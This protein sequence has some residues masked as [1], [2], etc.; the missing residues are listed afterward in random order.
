MV[1]ASS[2]GRRPAIRPRHARA[3]LV[4]EPAL[5]AARAGASALHDPTEGGLSAGL[6][7]MAEASGVALVVESERI[8]WFEPGVE[9]CVVAAGLDP[10]GTLASGDAAR[11][12]CIR[13]GGRCIAR[14][15]A[16][17]PL[18]VR[19]RS[20]R[21]R[22]RCHL[23]RRRSAHPLRTR[24][25]EPA[26]GRARRNDDRNDSPLA[27]PSFSAK[28][29][30]HS[31]EGMWRTTRANRCRETMNRHPPGG[32]GRDISGS[33]SHAF[34]RSAFCSSRISPSSI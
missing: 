2:D 20:R 12:V 30:R 23:H 21:A 14:S 3:S 29:G 31:V 28:A 22:V 18:G 13:P 9:L 1:S 16:R 7:E 15:R 4:V 17:R 10:W 5:A 8:L 11:G 25:A 24:R 26:L 32:I 19:H 6:H 34:P 33:Q 27:L